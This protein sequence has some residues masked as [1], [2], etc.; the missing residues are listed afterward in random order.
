MRIYSSTVLAPS[1]PREFIN[2]TGLQCKTL[3]FVNMN[4]CSWLV[5]LHHSFHRLYLTDS[6]QTSMH[7]CTYAHAQTAERCRRSSQGKMDGGT[8]EE[9]RWKG[10]G[11]SSGREREDKIISVH[12]DLWGQGKGRIEWRTSMRTGGGLRNRIRDG[13]LSLTPQVV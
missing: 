3:Q 12:G 9:M 1:K 11:K 5:L 2:R 4:V 10:G 6:W 8:R 13:G 7:S